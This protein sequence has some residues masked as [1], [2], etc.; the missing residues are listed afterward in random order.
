MALTLR[1]YPLDHPVIARA[2][3][4]LESFTI[5]EGDQRRLEAC[6]SPVW[7]TALAMIGL[8]DAGVVGDDPAMARATSWLLGEE[9]RHRG[10]WAVR[11]PNVE[12]GGWAFEFANDWY[13]DIDDAAEVMLALRRGPHGTSVDEAVARGVRWTLGMASSNGA[14]GAFE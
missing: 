10:D 12:A 7:D 13:P 8:A 5:V 3:R 6:Q 2:L 11:R 14:W 1:G 4:G 9:I